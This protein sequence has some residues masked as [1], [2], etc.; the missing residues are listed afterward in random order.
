MKP[1]R[2]IS[3]LVV[4]SLVGCESGRPS[5]ENVRSWL[6][7]IAGRIQR[8]A[9]ASECPIIAEA[10]ESS[11]FS[12]TF[13]L[14]NRGRD[15]FPVEEAFLL[16]RGGGNVVDLFAIGA[17]GDPLIALFNACCIWGRSF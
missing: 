16:W 13:T 9:E 10:I 14:R 2:I 7:G 5:A 12:A 1:L 8:S 15:P 4:L 17:N 11:P 3:L 6:T